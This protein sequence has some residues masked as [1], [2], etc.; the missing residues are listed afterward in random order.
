MAQRQFRS[1]D[2]SKW[3]DRFGNGSDGALTISADTTFSANYAT[4]TGTAASTSLSLN[5]AQSFTDGMLVIIHQTRGTGAGG[6]ELNKIS[7]GGGTTSLTMAYPLINTYV[8]GAQI[9]SMKQHSSVTID[10]TKTW[11][12]PSWN[13]STGGILAFFCNG[14]TT[15]TGTIKAS[16][17]NGATGNAPSTPATTTGGGFR[18]GQ[19]STNNGTPFSGEGSTT[20]VNA[21]VIFPTDNA[22]GGSDA[23]AGAGGSNGTQGQDGTNGSGPGRKGVAVGNAALTSMFFGGGGGGSNDAN[24]S[25]NPDM[26]SGGSGG[27][28]VLIISKVL[29]VT[30]SIAS[31]GGNGGT[32]NAGSGAGAGGS[33]LLKAQVLTLGNNLVVAT[34]GTGGATTNAYATGGNGGNGRIHADYS[35]TLSVTSTNP[36]LDSSL[37]LVFINPPSSGYAFF[38]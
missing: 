10:S 33:I 32:A 31:I 14:T 27:G 6:W 24:G 11:T 17:G 37:D 34:G 15:V 7:S 13:G 8:S 22:G 26:A 38:M 9:V 36:T 3:N 16:G 1:D 21:N 23:G 12:V 25:T 35:T 20:S 2:T 30:G 5:S 4:C 18:G 28:V 29:T 19:G